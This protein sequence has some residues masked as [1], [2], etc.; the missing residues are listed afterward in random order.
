M[1]LSTPMIQIIPPPPV[2]TY[3]GGMATPPQEHEP[4]APAP[5]TGTYRLLNVMGSPTEQV[6]R[7]RQGERLPGAPIAHTWRLERED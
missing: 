4:H 1:Q 7:V 6:V 2:S 3:P 5:V